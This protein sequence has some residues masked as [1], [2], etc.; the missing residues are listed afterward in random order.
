M[1]YDQAKELILVLTDLKNELKIQN[2]TLEGIDEG[3]SEVSMELFNIKQL[4]KGGEK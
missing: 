2:L 1:D 4:L 3:L